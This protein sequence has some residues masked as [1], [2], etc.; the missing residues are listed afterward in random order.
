MSE[1]PR[2][3]TI[4]QLFGVGCEGCGH[5]RGSFRVKSVSDRTVTRLVLDPQDVHLEGEMS[6]KQFGP[7][8]LEWNPD[9]LYWR[10]ECNGHEIVV[11]IGGHYQGSR[12]VAM[13]V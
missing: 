10:A 5:L 1:L 11:N 4:V 7:I 12:R 9:L 8:T 3:G 13:A 2:V 6:R